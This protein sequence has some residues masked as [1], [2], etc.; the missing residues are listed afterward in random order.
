MKIPI[1][2]KQNR[3]VIK[4]H[5]FR[6]YILK[7]VKSHKIFKNY[8]LDGRIAVWT[9]PILLL[10][11]GRAL[12]LMKIYRLSFSSAVCRPKR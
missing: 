9:L 11:T 1:S 7:Y 2:V 10:H 8:D 4:A 12:I 3:Q 5:T 6:Y